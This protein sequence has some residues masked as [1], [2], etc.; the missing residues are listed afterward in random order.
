MSG[1]G[2]QLPP[3][4]PRAPILNRVRPPAF[5]L[6]AVGVLNAFFSVLGLIFALLRI[7]SPVE[8]PPG[9]P[10]FVLEPSVGLMV[11]IAASLVCAG[12]TIWGCLNA[13]R[14]RGYAIA[15]MGTLTALFPLSPTCVLGVFI[16]P[17]MIFTISQQEVRKAFAP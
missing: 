8:P 17:W 15:L 6:L 14:L 3:T 1:P 10:P 13:M 4:D 9:Q 12:V 5:L 7:P 11:M 2:L 16:A